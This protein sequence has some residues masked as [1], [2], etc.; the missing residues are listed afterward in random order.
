MSPKK[1]YALRNG[2]VLERIYRQKSYRLT[3]V[4]KE[5]V[6][7][8]KISGKKFPSL[9]AAAKFVVGTNTTINGPWFWKAPIFKT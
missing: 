2:M 9:S 7:E 4:K 8:F 3:V 6:L 5:G 1:K